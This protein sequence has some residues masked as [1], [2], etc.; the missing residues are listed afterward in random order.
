MSDSGFISN[1]QNTPAKKTTRRPAPAQRAASDIS[2]KVAGSTAAGAVALLIAFTAG[3]LGLDIP[4][5]VQG[6]L[7]IVIAAVAG[8]FIPD[9]K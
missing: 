4:G 7:A 8:Y 9:N 3:Q 6:A 2:P 5:E 1:D